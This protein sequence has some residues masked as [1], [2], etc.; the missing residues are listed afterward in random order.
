MIPIIV[1]EYPAR[2]RV[3]DNNGSVTEYIRLAISIAEIMAPRL[4]AWS[5]DIRSTAPCENWRPQVT[6]MAIDVSE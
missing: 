6:S 5:R 1:S 3:S 2:D 4:R